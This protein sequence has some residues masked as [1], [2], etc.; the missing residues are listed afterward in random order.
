MPDTTV[1]NW[2]PIDGTPGPPDYTTGPPGPA[3]PPGPPGEDGQ[4]GIQGE[5][6]TPGPGWKVYQTPPT[7]GVNTGDPLGTIWYNSITGQFWTLT[8]ITPYTWTYSGT[9]VGAQGIQGPA[10]PQGAPGVPGPTGNT[11]PT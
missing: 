2:N 1:V 7:D 10:G 9:V 4:E 6:G 5:D 3:G 8:N 11:G